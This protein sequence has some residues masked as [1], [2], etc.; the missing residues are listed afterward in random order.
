METI[1]PNYLGGWVLELPCGQPVLG[2]V[3]PVRPYGSG[4]AVTQVPRRCPTSRI[5]RPC[6][7]HDGSGGGARGCAPGPGERTDQGC[8]IS[9][10]H[11]TVSGAAVGDHPGGPDPGWIDQGR[12]RHRRGAL[13][14]LPRVDR[15]GPVDQPLPELDSGDDQLD[16]L[17]TPSPTERPFLGCPAAAPSCRHA[18]AGGHGRG[19]RRGLP[20]RKPLGAGHEHHPRVRPRAVWSGRRESNPRSQFGRLGLYH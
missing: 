13:R 8:V 11:F 12:T 10:G 7:W 20:A 1:A 5:R 17:L 9:C 3:A 4:K 14:L 18:P 19:R 15:H 6:W 16:Q 2:P